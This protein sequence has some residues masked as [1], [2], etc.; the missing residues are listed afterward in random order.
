MI[1][2]PS[3]WACGEICGALTPNSDN[4]TMPGDFTLKATKWAKYDFGPHLDEVSFPVGSLNFL[5]FSLGR[6]FSVG[7]GCNC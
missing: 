2:L 4:A 1:A 3:N 7:L 6:H 5:P